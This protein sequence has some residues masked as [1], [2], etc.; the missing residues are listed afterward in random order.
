MARKKKTTEEPGPTHNVDAADQADQAL[1][2][3]H[4][5][6]IRAAKEE[7]AAANS[8]LRHA[9]KIAKSDLGEDAKQD[10]NDSLAWDDKG[11]EMAVQAELA[12]LRRLARWNG[13]SLG[14]QAE[15]FRDAERHATPAELG[16]LAGLNGDEPSPPHGAETP[17]GQ[18]YMEAW[19]AGQREIFNIQKA[20]DA[21]AFAEDE[22]DE[23]EGEGND[24]E[25][26]PPI[27]EAAPPSA[28]DDGDQL[29]DASA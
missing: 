20:K 26:P 19:H 22:A 11:G 24:E 12:R 1:F 8:A 2:F 9:Y 7:L 3:H 17:E 21:E 14:E 18:E 27:G 6:K 4:K 15:L 10:I 16:R 25:D 29:Q 5:R 28:S 13:F 23:T